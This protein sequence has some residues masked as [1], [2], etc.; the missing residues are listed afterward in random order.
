[1]TFSVW[2]VSLAI[3]EL[4]LPS[5]KRLRTNCSKGDSSR[6]AIVMSLAIVNDHLSAVYLF[7]SFVH[8]NITPRMGQ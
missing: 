4:D 3:A 1:M 8:P 5:H 6:D 7:S 2:A